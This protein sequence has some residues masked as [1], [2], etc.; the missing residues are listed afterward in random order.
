[1]FNVYCG[2][3]T[4]QNVIHWLPINWISY[5]IFYSYMQ[6]VFSPTPFQHYSIGGYHGINIDAT[7]GGVK[8]KMNFAFF[9]S[10]NHTNEIS[11][12]STGLGK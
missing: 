11:K 6:E 8:N 3:L 2:T 4:R 5:C 9:Q 12:P 1:M 10:E 7:K